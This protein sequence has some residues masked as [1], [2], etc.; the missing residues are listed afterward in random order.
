MKRIHIDLNLFN[1][2]EASI[3]YFCTKIELMK[4][5]FLVLGGSIGAILRYLVSIFSIRYF[6]WGLPLGTL[7]VNMIGSFLIGFAFVF[8]GRE[9]MALNL[10]IF[11]FIGIFGS[12]TT[13]STYMF[14]ALDFIKT[15]NIKTALYY[16]GISNIVGLL[17]VFVGYYLG[18]I[19]E[20]A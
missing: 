7:L 9:S 5:L 16:I 6:A 1:N 19:V 13:F 14:E 11:L 20:K 8:L 17:A 15:G 12:F 3:Y 18:E 4:F 2:P 10:K